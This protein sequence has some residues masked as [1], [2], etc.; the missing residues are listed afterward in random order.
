MGGQWFSHK[1]YIDAL[2]VQSIVEC[3]NENVI[4]LQHTEIAN[5]ERIKY[6]LIEENYFKS[7]CSLYVHVFISVKHISSKMAVDMD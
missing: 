6:K 3:C 7:T 5:I 4:A 1:M 2:K